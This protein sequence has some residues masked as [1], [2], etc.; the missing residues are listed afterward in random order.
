LAKK[1]STATLREAIKVKKKYLQQFL[2][3]PGVVGIGIGG[4]ENSA[5]IV[6]NVIKITDE[7]KR[8][9]PKEID[10]IPVEIIETG[11]VRALGDT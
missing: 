5:K 4:R 1:K 7:I 2:N 10:G 6:V 3:I 9:I 11:V 8:K